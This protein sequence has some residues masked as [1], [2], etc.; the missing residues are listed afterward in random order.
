[1]ASTPDAAT[2]TSATTKLSDAQFPSHLLIASRRPTVSN[3]DYST[4]TDTKFYCQ[5][6]RRQGRRG[7]HLPAPVPARCAQL[8]WMPARELLAR[9][10]ADPSLR[11][12]LTR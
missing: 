10:A 11:P 5:A 1:M 6:E 7:T 3:T 8:L 4:Q 2:A 9:I 12:R